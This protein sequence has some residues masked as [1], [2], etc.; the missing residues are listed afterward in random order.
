MLARFLIALRFLRAFDGFVEHG[1]ELRAGAE[2]VHRAAL[3]QGL[4]HALIEKP[5][6]HFV[7][8]LEDGAELPKLLARIQD[9]IDCSASNVLYRSKA[10]TNGFAVGCE[11][12]VADV[13]IRRLDG[14]AHLAAL[15]DVLD[16]L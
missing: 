14:N 10:E 5:E 13:N 16:D 11:V 1:H 6:I 15:V 2:A 12:R 7:A 3:D 8:E 9:G 4:Q